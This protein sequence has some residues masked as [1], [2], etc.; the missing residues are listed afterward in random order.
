M[1]NIL[2]WGALALSVTADQISTF[3]DLTRKAS[4]KTE[5]K[6]SGTNKPK[7]VNK[8]PELQTAS[9]KAELL[10][11]LGVDVNKAIE[12]WMGASESGDANE[13]YIGGMKF[14]G[15]RWQIKDVSVSNATFAKDVKTLSGATLAIN[16]VEWVQ[17]NVKKAVK[18]T[19]T[20]A[21]KPSSTVVPSKTDT[22]ITQQYKQN[23]MR[24]KG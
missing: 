8:G 4:Y 2:S 7:T 18:K 14:G 20:A 1:P 11:Q 13:I 6:E 10:A 17:T 19:T 22:K 15:N 5:T 9:V 3:T 21:K 23:V 16:F 24:D 12:D